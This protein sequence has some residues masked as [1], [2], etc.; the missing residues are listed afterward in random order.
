M[1]VCA[2]QQQQELPFC[3]LHVSTRHTVAQHF[4]LMEYSQL[5]VCHCASTYTEGTHDGGF[6]LHVAYMHVGLENGEGQLQAALA[7]WY[8]T[9]ECLLQCDSTLFISIV[10]QSRM[11]D[12]TWYRCI[13]SGLPDYLL[14][15]SENMCQVARPVTPPVLQGGARFV[16]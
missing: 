2:D 8:D 9:P 4:C 12:I 7:C 11:V 15:T 1:S 16:W 14:D 5:S 13:I 10:L 6:K 3:K